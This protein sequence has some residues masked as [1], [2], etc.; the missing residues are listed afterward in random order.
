MPHKLRVG[1]LFIL[2]FENER[3]YLVEEFH[4]RF[5]L[6]GVILFSRN[7][8]GA[9]S[10]RHRLD[11]LRSVT[12]PDLLI[13]VDQE[14]GR[15]TRLSGIDF[16]AYPSPAY[17]GSRND[18]DG[19]IHAASV[20]ADRLKALG[21]NFNLNPVADVLTNSDNELMRDRCYSGDA[22]PVGGYVAGI[23]EVQNSIGVA[24]CVKHFPGLGD[25]GMDPHHELAVSDRSAEFYREVNFR[26][27]REAIQANCPAIMTTHMLTKALDPV[28]PATF[29]IDI[30]GRILRD[31]LQ[32]EGVVMSDDLDMGAVARPAEAA[33]RAIGAGHDLVLV[34]HSIDDQIS[35]AEEILRAVDDGTLDESTLIAGIERVKK[36]KTEFSI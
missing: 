6:G 19:A 21:I 3:L 13:S 17:F 18:L 7:Y 12:A 10:L 28:Q 23:V 29:S 27:F 5:G 36:L 4:E 11:H 31:E 24:S 8:D 16:P 34:C 9:D 35:C 30:C 32:F 33:V 1:E 26:P 2:G 25:C 22:V 20:T 14:G 15:V